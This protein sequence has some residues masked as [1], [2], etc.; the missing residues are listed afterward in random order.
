MWHHPKIAPVAALAT[1]LT[2]AAVD[3]LFNTSPTIVCILATGGLSGLMAEN[4]R[5]R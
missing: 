3:N 4:L 2:L 5:V 1:I